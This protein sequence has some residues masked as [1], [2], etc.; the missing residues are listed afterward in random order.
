MLL[1]NK[2][3]IAREMIKSEYIK[4]NAEKNFD[5]VVGNHLSYD[6]NSGASF[7]LTIVRGEELAQKA[8][9]QQFKDTEIS[10]MRG[11]IYDA[12]GNVLAQS[13]SVWNVFIDPLNIKDDEERQLI[14][15][16]F[17]TLFKYDDEA[18]KEFYEKQLIKIIMS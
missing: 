3:T 17:A 13:A 10:A 12:N 18:K 1:L 8:E 2:I 4:E 14:T 9:S 16:E 6:N 15:N 11:T 5:N 7:Y